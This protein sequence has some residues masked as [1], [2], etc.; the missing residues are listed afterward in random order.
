M[1]DTRQ[2]KF[3]AG[4]FVWSVRAEVESGSET[5]SLNQ[6]SPLA[7]H[8]LV[9]NSEEPE[10]PQFKLPLVGGYGCTFINVGEQKAL[11]EELASLTCHW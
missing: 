11:R 7:P 1:E 6:S 9:Q 2:L 3:S 10:N 5:K 8:L 4:Y